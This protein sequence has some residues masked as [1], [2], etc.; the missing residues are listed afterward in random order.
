M[1]DLTRFGIGA[2][3]LSF[4]LAGCAGNAQID[5]P[6]LHDASFQVRTFKMEN[7]RYNAVGSRTERGAEGMLDP[8]GEAQKIMDA[9]KQTMDQICAPRNAVLVASEVQPLVIAINT[10][11]DCVKT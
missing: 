8:G 1:A 7:N 11:F 10:L 9:I 2:T 4:I 3:L 6:Y 5:Y